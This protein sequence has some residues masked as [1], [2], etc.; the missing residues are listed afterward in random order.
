MD[1]ARDAGLEVQRGIVVDDHLRTSDDAIFAAGDIA[2]HRGRINGLWPT[3]VEQ[4][5]VAADNAVGGDREYVGTSPVTVLK[6][7]G[8]EL[9]SIGR[10]EPEDG[11]EVI[12]LEEAGGQR[13]RKLVIADGKVA[14]AILLGFSQDVSPIRTAISR[15][16]DVTS[17]LEEL[18]EG[19][20]EVMAELTEDEPLLPAAAAHPGSG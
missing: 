16:L 18:R 9:T 20:W 10:F 6:V 14:G 8:V 4:A 15:G 19:R 11:D 13:Y 3:A 1:L 5:E 12:A 2:E 17:R 7:V